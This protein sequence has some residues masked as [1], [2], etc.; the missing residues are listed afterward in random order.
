MAAPALARDL[1]S[2]ASDSA[3]NDSI[4]LFTFLSSSLFFLFLNIAGDFS[5]SEL[6]LFQGGEHK[7]DDGERLS[8]TKEWGGGNKGDK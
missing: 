8:R 3:L 1:F 2:P 6:Y 4:K 7:G 5:S